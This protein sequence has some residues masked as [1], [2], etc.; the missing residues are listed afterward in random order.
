MYPQRYKGEE[1][2]PIKIHFSEEDDEK[3]PRFRTYAIWQDVD[4]LGEKLVMCTECR[5]LYTE[6]MPECPFC[7]ADMTHLGEILK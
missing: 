2:E 7:R 3:L 5:H 4:V 1:F 6:R